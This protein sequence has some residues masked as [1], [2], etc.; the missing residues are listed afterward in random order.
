MTGYISKKT[1]TIQ[2]Q[3][4]IIESWLLQSFRAEGFFT[5]LIPA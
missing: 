4:V 2:F 3:M 1:A 5:K